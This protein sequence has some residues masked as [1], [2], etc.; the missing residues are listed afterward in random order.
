MTDRS[1]LEETEAR[2]KA[3]LEEYGKFLRHAIAQVC[4]RQLGIQ[5]DDI[6]QEARLRLWRA[7]ESEREIRDV[8]SYLYKVAVTTTID[9]IRKVKARREEQLRLPEEDER[10][11]M[12]TLPLA[13]PQKSPEWV[14]EHR[15][16]IGMVEEALSML[17]ERRRRAVALYLQGLNTAEI[18]E[19]LGW[20]EPKARN[21]LYRGLQD[22]RQHLR[23]RGI[24]C[25]ID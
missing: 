14:A 25:E 8:A 7:L 11:G 18:A 6:E 23:V 20:S 2:F 12:T 4:P 24:D 22:L 16:L 13:D 19:L 5:L 10:N 17:P 9:A 21:L 15:Q 1:P 3:V